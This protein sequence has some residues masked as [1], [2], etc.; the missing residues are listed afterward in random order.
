VWDIS[1]RTLMLM[2]VFLVDLVVLAD[3]AR[4]EIHSLRIGGPDGGRSR[5]STEDHGVQQGVPAEGA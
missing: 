1:W 2:L 4:A 5:T 3:L